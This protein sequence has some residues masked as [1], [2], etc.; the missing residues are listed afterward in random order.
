MEGEIEPN[1]ADEGAGEVIAVRP[2]V[3]NSPASVGAPLP[4]Y[5]PGT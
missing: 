3:A 5:A 2:P 1:D 4:R